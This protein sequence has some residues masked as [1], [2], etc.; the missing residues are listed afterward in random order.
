MNDIGD[1]TFKISLV[2]NAI[3]GLALDMVIQG[4]FVFKS[5]I[6]HSEMREKV[7]EEN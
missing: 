2:A 3:Q 6:G 1:F 4:Q 7:K 5:F